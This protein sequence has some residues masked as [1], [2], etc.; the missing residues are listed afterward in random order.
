M[1]FLH[2]FFLG[3]C[4]SPTCIITKSNFPKKRVISQKMSL[5]ERRLISDIPANKTETGKKSLITLFTSIFKKSKHLSD[6][7]CQLSPKKPNIEKKKPNN[8]FWRQL[9]QKKPSLWNLA[10]KK[11]IWEPCWKMTTKNGINNPSVHWIDCVFLVHKLCGYYNKGVYVEVIRS[12][13]RR[14]FRGRHHGPAWRCIYLKNEPHTK[15]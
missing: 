12:T 7:M 6:S 1:K 4:C 13:T 15:P 14:Y 8:F 2:N 5:F 3:G 10:S 11:P 9:S